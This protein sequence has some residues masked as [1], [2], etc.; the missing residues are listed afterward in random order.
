[1]PLP[2]NVERLERAVR[3]APSARS[4]PALRA[5]V[6]AH[7]DSLTRG[8]SSTASVPAALEP[9]VRK[10]VLEA[11]K[12]LDRDL[13]TPR[14]AGSSVDELFEVTVAAAL[15]AG[16]TRLEIAWRA[17]DEALPGERRI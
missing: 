14:A 2:S 8:E 10:V 3:S 1:M 5:A 13:E 9:Y 6:L 4:S 17:I 7:A 11:Y 16:L 12:V 15:G